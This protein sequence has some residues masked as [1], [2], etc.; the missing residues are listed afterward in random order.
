MRE[1]LA[2]AWGP[3]GQRAKNMRKRLTPVLDP[4][5]QRSSGVEASH[6]H[7]RR[8]RTRR[9][10]PA[11][12][13]RPKPLFGGEESPYCHVLLSIMQSRAPQLM[14]FALQMSQK[15]SRPTLQLIR[16]APMRQK[17]DLTRRFLSPK[18]VQRGRL[19]WPRRESQS[20]ARS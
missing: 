5:G 9:C 10:A 12:E 19:R 16:S 8:N 15:T 20:Y 6:H 2:R 3:R 11:G 7:H 4:R 18:K 14:D 13:G 17:N 1:K